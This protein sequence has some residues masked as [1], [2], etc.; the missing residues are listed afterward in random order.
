MSRETDFLLGL[1][2]GL[3]NR[4]RNQ[5]IAAGDTASIE[6]IEDDYQTLKNGI[7]QTYYGKKPTEKSHDK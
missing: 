6:L 4:C 2:F 7:E 3:L 5:F 1:S